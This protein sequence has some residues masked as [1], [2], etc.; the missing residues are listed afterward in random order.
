MFY[1]SGTHISWQNIWCDVG[2]KRL[3]M[4]ALPNI[5][6]RKFNVKNDT[7][8]A[9]RSGDNQITNHAWQ[10]P[11]DRIQ[12]DIL[13][14]LHHWLPRPC[15]ISAISTHGLLYES[16]WLENLLQ[17]YELFVS[18]LCWSGSGFNLYHDHRLTRGHFLQRCSLSLD[19]KS[20]HLSVEI[21][22]AVLKINTRNS[23][24]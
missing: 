6:F 8:V 2:C 9:Y 23:L 5:Q 24:V 22:I 10:L 12:A 20:L 16:S 11:E 19:C 4:A 13:N 3:R 21:V 7:N 18:F 1:I 15:F 14:W 17:I